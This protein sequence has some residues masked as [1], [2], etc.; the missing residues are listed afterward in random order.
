[1]IYEGGVKIFNA[2]N[3]KFTFDSPEAVKWLQMYVDMVKDR[4][5]DNTVR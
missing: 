2:D 1:M 5:V 4:T 3:T